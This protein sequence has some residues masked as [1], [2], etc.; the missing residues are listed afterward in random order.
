MLLA[1]M[2]KPVRG[3]KEELWLSNKVEPA[4]H[5]ANVRQFKNRESRREPERKVSSFSA[6]H[7][8]MAPGSESGDMNGWDRMKLRERE[9]ERKGWGHRHICVCESFL[10]LTGDQA[11]FRN[12]ISLF[13]RS[14]RKSGHSWILL[15]ERYFVRKRTTKMDISRHV[16]GSWPAFRAGMIH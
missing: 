2:L 7:E 11:A 5:G 9:R 14:Y 3:F 12:Y 8:Q 16:W 13:N 4:G 15:H 10:L 6:K 1:V